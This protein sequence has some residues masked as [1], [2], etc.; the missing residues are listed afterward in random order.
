MTETFNNFVG[1]EWKA[2]RGGTL[3]NE[4]PA[5][6]RSNLGF[7]QSSTAEDIVEAIEPRP[8]AFRTWRRTIGG[9]ATAVHRRVS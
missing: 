8:T 4:N 2:S 5:V 7:F 3:R 6:Q 1:G 9:R